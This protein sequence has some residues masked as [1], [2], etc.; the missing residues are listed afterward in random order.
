MC[1]VLTASAI[2]LPLL[3]V[4]LAL[5]I[6]RCR[7]NRDFENL[8]AAVDE[9]VGSS[10]T[11]EQAHTHLLP[12]YCLSHSQFNR[13][14]STNPATHSPMHTLHIVA[15]TL[16]QGVAEGDHFVLV[17]CGAGVCVRVWN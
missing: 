13:P 8:R 5:N 12:T 6:K 10:R 1:I 15:L 4:Q 14:L 2:A 7:E 3:Q 17:F 16:A 11:F 9:C